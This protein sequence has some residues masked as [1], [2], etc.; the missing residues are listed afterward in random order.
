[1]TVNPLVAARVE[2][3]KDAWAGVWIAEDIEL[4]GQGIKSG[5]WVDSGLGVVGTSLDGLAIMSDPVGVLLQYGISWIIEHVKPLSEALDW[6]AG[7]PAQ[8]AA[9]AKTWRNVAASLHD[10]V[11]DLTTAVRRDVADWGGS[12][13]PAYQA[14]ARQQQDAIG[15]L[16]RAAETMA[17]ITEG[18]GFLIAAVRILVRDAIATVVSRLIVYAAEEVA[19]L[20]FGT[21]L[22][23]EQVASLVA[24]WAA[25]IARWLKA[26]LASLRQLMP[27]IH[28]LGELISDLK[29]ILNRLRGKTDTGADGAPLQR[30]R[31][32][33]AGPRQAMTLESVRQ[34]AAKYGIDVSRLK[35][36]INKSVAG[37]FG[38][39]R[40]D[41]SVELSRNAFQS[42]ED[43]ARTLE[44]ER[45]HSE[46]LAGGKP[47]PKTMEEAEP[48]ED[49]AY[50][51]EDDWWQNQP[52]RPEGAR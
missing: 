38:R 15:G 28:R 1:M 2:G 45:F 37:R 12:A 31:G 11:T 23:V 9:H 51:H 40:P 35:I 29:K 30:V 8:I 10:S 24:S 43:L 33:G 27:I 4:I 49:R 34:I 7:D 19:T 20:G 25:K 14:W 48:W 39:T 41:G 32:K 52:V 13:G 46:E 42:E 3:P 21:P 22:V 26:L 6:L 44:H 47:Y 18:A 36:D 50:A 5:S 17:A 16:A